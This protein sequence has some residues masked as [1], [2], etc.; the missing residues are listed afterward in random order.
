MSL[1]LNT[2]TGYH[3]CQINIPTFLFNYR[4]ITSKK[5]YNLSIVNKNVYLTN[6]KFEIKVWVLNCP[7]YE[8]DFDIL[9]LKSIAWA[10]QK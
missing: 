10:S 7:T 5:K 4:Y 2:A 8:T 1:F 6:K 9:Y 3:N